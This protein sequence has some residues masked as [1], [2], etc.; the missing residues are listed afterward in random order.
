MKLTHIGSLPF[1][2]VAQAL[3]YTFKWDVPVLF[4]LPKLNS[5]EF[6]GHDL[7]SLMGVD[8]GSGVNFLKIDPEFKTKAI[9]IIPFHLEPFIKRLKAHGSKQFKYQLLGP[10]SFY[11]LIQ[12]KD[13]ISF[14]EFS[15]FLL[16]K[17]KTLLASLSEHGDLIFVLDEPFLANQVHFYTESKFIDELTKSGAEV[18]IHCCAKLKVEDIKQ[19]SSIINIDYHLYNDSEVSQFSPLEFP[20]F[21]WSSQDLPQNIGVL[22]KSMNNAQFLSPSCGLAF[23]S[24]QE[25]EA[26]IKGL[27]FLKKTLLGQD[28]VIR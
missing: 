15:E 24:I 20:G 18:F 4:T 12:N 6:I 16:Y 14:G 25:V 11:H 13:S 10:I 23:K 7:L 3:D 1:L 27:Q 5:C 21:T 22:K 17:Y 28:E 26:T 8:Y 9:D 2:S 19:L